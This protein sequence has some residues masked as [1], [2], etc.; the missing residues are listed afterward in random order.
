ML[1][2]T[3]AVLAALLVIHNAEN[4]FWGEIYEYAEDSIFQSKCYD[5]DRQPVATQILNPTWH[6]ARMS[7]LCITIHNFARATGT[8]NTNF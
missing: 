6:T 2:Q 4:G 3:C 7:C 5:L 1:H 8:E